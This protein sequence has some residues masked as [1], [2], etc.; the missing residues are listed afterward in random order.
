MHTLSRAPLPSMRLIAL[1]VHACPRTLCRAVLD[2][3][4]VLEHLVTHLS[5]RAAQ[6]LGSTCRALRNH[7]AILAAPTGVQAAPGIVPHTAADLAF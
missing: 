4:P 5:A 2:L 6:L 7:V 1:R 3:E